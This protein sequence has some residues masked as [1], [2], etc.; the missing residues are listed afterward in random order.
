MARLEQHIPVRFEHLGDLSVAL[1]H[2]LLAM[3]MPKE[4]TMNKTYQ[5]LFIG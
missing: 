1:C 5:K 3:Y 4:V 2:K